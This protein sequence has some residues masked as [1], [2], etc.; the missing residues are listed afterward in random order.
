M[1]VGWATGPL[2]GG[3]IES[4][5]ER[6]AARAWST[7]KVPVIVASITCGRADWHAIDSAITRSDND[8]AL[9][10][11]ATLDDGPAQ[12]EAVLRQAGDPDTVLEREPDPRGWSP[13]GR[14]VWTLEAGATFY[15]ALARGE[16]L[17]AADTERV[18]DAM[19]QVVPAQC[20]G[21]GRIPGV[22][23]KGGWG[24]S[25]EP[26]GGYEVIQFGIAGDSVLALSAVAADFSSAQE[27]AS[28]HVPQHQNASQLRAARD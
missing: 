25:E 4:F 22:R 28:R 21:L 9:R 6:R 2:G 15:R 5:G 1:P 20:W 27:L 18:L 17:G 14:T 11:W 23:F 7:M 13:F 24:P 19:A 3:A 12:V 26:G 8:A 16:L 10:L